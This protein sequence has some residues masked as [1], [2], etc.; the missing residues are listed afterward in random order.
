MIIAYILPSLVV[1]LVLGFI[2]RLL[3]GRM[4]VKSAEQKAKEL[5]VSAEKDIE[6]KR[7][8]AMI[9]A[10]DRLLQEK[11]E[12]EKETRERRLELQKIETRLLTKEENIERKLNEVEQRTKTLTERE[13]VVEKKDSELS[14]IILKQRTELEKISGLS[15]AEAKEMLVQSIEKQ[16]RADASKLV[17][18]IETEAKQI[19]EKKAQNVITSAIQ[20]TATEVTAEIAVSTVA[21]PTDEM[22]GR[23]IGREGRNIRALETLTGVDIIIDDTPEAIVLSCFEPVRREIARIAIERLISDGRIHPA[24]I[25][26]IIN[27][28]RTDIENVIME[29]G[30]KACFDLNLQGVSTELQKYVGRLKYRYSYGQNILNHSREV[31]NIA[32]IVAAEVGADIRLCKTAGLLHDIGKGIADSEGGHATVGADVARKLGMNKTV[33]N[34]IAAH[35][36]DVPPESVEAVVVQVADA[37]S[38]SRPG[39]RKESFDNY[40]KRLTNLEKIAT[41]YEKVDKAFAIQAGRELRIIMDSES[42]SDE[43]IRT[44][45]RGIAGRIEDELKYPG[46]IKVTAIRETRIVEYTK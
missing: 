25:E 41:E 5:L 1:G 12:F 29:E 3:I 45:A 43:E 16:A 14:D 35:H 26:E 42:T 21:L 10:K 24:R 13:R 2:I 31:A 44:I 8:E 36:F 39:A 40:L 46:Q 7:K 15:S 27:K 20:R 4:S 28:V 30:E 9:E 23:I 11:N 17:N 37:I 34:A 32:G 18:K 6:H 33:V 38:A 22:K 19:A